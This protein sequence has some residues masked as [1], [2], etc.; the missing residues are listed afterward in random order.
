MT[1]RQKS[2]VRE[3]VEAIAIAVVLA[4]AIRTFVV[5]AFKIPS[6]S[7]IPTLL[8]GDHLLVNKLVYRFRLP[9]RNEV[10]VFKFPQ[11]RKTDFIKRVVALPGDEIQLDDGT[12]VL[13]GAPAADEHASYGP[14]RPAGRERNMQ[15]FRVPKK[16]ETLRLE[17]PNIELYRLMIANELKES[18]RQATVDVVDGRV[19]IDGKPVETWQVTDDYLFMMGDNRD[20]SFDSR[21]WG[22]VRREDIVGKAMIIYWS[23]GNRL[24]QIRWDR[25][26]DLIH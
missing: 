9:E 6:G 26:G 5:Q 19:R 15:P 4:L 21:F 12:L 22:P 14:G 2:L 16:G 8:V 3:Y 7:M 1:A 17:G 10:V 20:N 11:D 25:L 24:W 23:F 13:N 18:E